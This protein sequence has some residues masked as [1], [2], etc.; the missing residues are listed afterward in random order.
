MTGQHRRDEQWQ[1]CAVVLVPGK[2]PR[3]Y[4]RMPTDLTSWDKSMQ[5]GLGVDQGRIVA[6]DAEGNEFSGVCE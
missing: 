6:I 2:D 4:W 3:T 5:Y 1:R